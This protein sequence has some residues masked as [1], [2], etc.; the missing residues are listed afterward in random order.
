[1]KDKNNSKTKFGIEVKKK[2]VELNMTQRELAKKLQMNENYL[3]D[4]LSG[5]RSGK[6]YKAKIIEILKID[7]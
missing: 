7:L 5:R 3:T 4:I 6:K 2:L 1:M